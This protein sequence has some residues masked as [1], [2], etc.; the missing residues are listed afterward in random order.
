MSI[1]KHGKRWNRYYL[2]MDI[3]DIPIC[4][5]DKLTLS[6]WA[7]TLIKYYIRQVKKKV[8]ET[9]VFSKDELKLLHSLARED[10]HSNTRLKHRLASLSIIFQTSTE[11]RLSELCAIQYSNIEGNYINYRKNIPPRNR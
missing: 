1:T 7:H 11:L 4:K 2:C 3:I 9:Q 5:L 10:Y 8:N 6:N